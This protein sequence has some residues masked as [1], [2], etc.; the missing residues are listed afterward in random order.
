MLFVLPLSVWPNQNRPISGC[1]GDPA[2]RWGCYGQATR[3]CRNNQVEAECVRK[4]RRIS[5]AIEGRKNKAK[6]CV[7]RRT[8]RNHKRNGCRNTKEE[9]VHEEN[10]ARQQRYQHAWESWA[11]ALSD[12]R[13]NTEAQ[14]HEHY[15]NSGCHCRCSQRF[16]RHDGTNNSTKPSTANMLLLQYCYC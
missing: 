14:E 8:V 12:K 11:G 2:G 6:M 13:Q 4:K 5:R 7:N 3:E 1:L 15:W 9:C 10:R 16:P